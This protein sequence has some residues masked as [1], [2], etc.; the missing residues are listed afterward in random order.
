MR[1][2]Y[3]MILL[4]AIFGSIN[5]FAAE[6]ASKEPSISQK[7]KEL[8]N[9]CN[10]EAKNALVHGD[11]ELVDRLCMEAVKEI[12]ESKSGKEYMINPLMNLAFSYSMAGLSEKA[13]PVYRRARDLGEALYGS[14][15]PELNKIEKMVAAHEEMKR[16]E[17]EK[18]GKARKE[19]K[20][21][22]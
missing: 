1:I 17:S 7:G 21:G 5:T 15:S 3:V 2:L 16:R 6:A 11:L 12:E 22:K 4:S 10:M 14:G 18:A 13:D 8:S 19:V 20:V 9:Q